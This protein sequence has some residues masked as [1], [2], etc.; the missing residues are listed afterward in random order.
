MQAGYTLGIAAADG[1]ALAALLPAGFLEE[2]GRV[3]DEVDKARLGATGAA[4]EAKQATSTQNNH[5]R[6]IKVWQRKVSRRA[7]RAV[8]AGLSVPAELAIIGSNQAV[9]AT[10]EQATKLVH[11]LAQN[12]AT[13]ATVGPD[14]QPLIDEG[15]ELCRFLDQADSAQEQTRAAQLPAAVAA[16]YAKKGELYTALKI[17]NDAGHELH[18]DDAAAAARYNLSI[19]HRRPTKPAATAPTP[20]PPA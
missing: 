7:K 16:F 15:R 13:L 11:L 6:G 10:L 8:H 3:R 2:V 14:V 4:I 9:P 19:L 18:A 17:I 5:L 20:T 1:A 12:A